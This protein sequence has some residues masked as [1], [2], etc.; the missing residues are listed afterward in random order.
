MPKALPE[1]IKV[2]ALEMV[3]DGAGVREAAR[4]VGVSPMA[5]S[6]LAR[7]EGV[8]VPTERTAPAIAAN[9][10]RWAAKRQELAETFGEMASKAARKANEA[11]D[12][13]RGSDAKAF[14]V[15][16]AIATDKHLLLTGEATSRS[17]KVLPPAEQQLRILELVATLEARRLAS[18]S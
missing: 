14:A 5:V 2:E 12:D 8:V 10:E 1:S 18:G 9:K 4:A 11:M 13:D 6:R 17:E 15:T 16:A 3:R 7:S